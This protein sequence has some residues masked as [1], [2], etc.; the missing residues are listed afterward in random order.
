MAKPISIFCEFTDRELET[1]YFSADLLKSLKYMRPLILFL[2]VLNTLFIVPDFILIKDISPLIVIAVTR[3]IFLVCALLL[4]F[5]IQYMK[6]PYIICAWISACELLGFLSFIIIFWQYPSP[7]YLIQ[8]LGMIIIILAVFLVPNR[9]LYMVITSIIGVSSFFIAAY[10]KL[11]DRISTSRFSAGIVYTAL[12]IIISA[13]SSYRMY[14]NRRAN[15]A[16]NKELEKTSFTDSLTG[17]INKAKLNEELNMWMKFSSRYKTP[18]TLI[19]FDIDNFKHINDEYGHLVGDEVMVK[20]IGAVKEMIR[21]TDTLARWGGDEFTIIMPHTNRIQA[22]EITE[23]IRKAISERELMPEF[24]LSCSFGIASFTGKGKIS[25][26]DQF[27]CA[28]DRALY[29]AKNSGKNVVMY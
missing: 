14:Y 16:I 9:W 15:Y 26:V 6:S 24:K 5:H 27:I 19:L 18:L 21:E 8:V 12:I 3:V 22:L 4:Y 10:A 20:I 1:E 11:A 23:R 2:A 17:L 25:G 29:K 13:F 28:A 7:D